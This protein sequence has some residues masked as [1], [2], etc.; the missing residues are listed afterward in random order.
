MQ[1]CVLLV[2]ILNAFCISTLA[3]IKTRLKGVV[4]DTAKQPLEFTVVCLVELNDTTKNKCVFSD[5]NGTFT[6]LNVPEG[7]YRIKTNYMGYTPFISDV[8]TIT[9][10][11][12]D[13][14]ILKDIVLKAGPGKTLNEVAITAQKPLIEKKIDRMVL[15]VENSVIAKGNSALEILQNA[16]GVGESRNGNLSLR[17]KE[18]TMI[19]INDKPTYLSTSDLAELLRNTPGTNVQS[20]ELITNPPAKYEAQG[21]GGII[22][23]K[24]KT[25]KTLGANYTINALAGYG[26]YYKWNTGIT[27]N[28]RTNK[29]NISANYIT[30]GNQRFNDQTVQRFNTNNGIT[31]RFDQDADRVRRIGYNHFNVSLEYYPDSKN[32]FRIFADGSFLAAKQTLYNNTLISKEAAKLDSSYESVAPLKSDYTD[33]RYGASYEHKLDTNGTTLGF[34]FNA[35]RFDAREVTQYNNAYFL[36]DRSPLHTSDTL[37]I[38]SPIKIDIYSFNIDFSHP[39]LKNKHVLSA[40]LKFTYVKTNNNFGYDSLRNGTFF[41]TIFSNHFLYKENVNA[42]YI[43]YNFKEEKTAIQAGLR[44]EQTNSEG[45]SLNSSSESVKRHYIDFFP[46]FFIDQQISTSSTINFAYSRRIDRPSYEDLNPFVYFLDQFT[47]T[48]GNPFLKPQYSNSFEFNYTLKEKY[49]AS[50]SYVRIGQVMSEVVKTDP[51]SKTLIFS[52]DNLARENVYSLALT[53]P[54]TFTKWWSGVFFFNTNFNHIT[55]PDFDGI[56]L[57]YQ[58]IAYNFTANQTVNISNAMKC[59]LNFGFQSPYI[60]GTI[61]YNKPQYGLD[62]GISRTFSKHLNVAF[63]LKDIFDTR[64][65]YFTSLL[66]N[67]HYQ[68]HQKVETRIARLT[69]TYKFGNNKIPKIKN[70]TNSSQ[71]EMNRIKGAN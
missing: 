18:G 22:N 19:L 14:V 10:T 35:G 16:P 64:A 24:M 48:Q 69:V 1:K 60:T 26:R 70:R 40:G 25:N 4:T 57:N 49:N 46:S 9:A 31:T 30:S 62:F 58:R 61:F 7:N 8:L 52:Y 47:F 59:E 41:S 55:T 51:V 44:V 17:G 42:G 3:Q 37:R 28:F 15:N 33:L 50:L 13:S 53:A 34:D 45:I 71:E 29:T 12:G 27:A 39:W 43:N 56:P 23:I 5:A 63:S 38:S 32:T 21:T 68:Y 11:S 36:A 65:R 66:P 2:L 54:V 20:I 67:Q 6:L